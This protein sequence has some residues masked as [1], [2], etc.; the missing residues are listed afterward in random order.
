MIYP[1]Y[2][3]RG[4]HEENRLKIC[5]ICLKKSKKMCLINEKIISFI[6]KIENYNLDDIKYPKVVCNVCKVKVYKC[7]KENDFSLNLT[8]L[9][10]FSL[11]KQSTRNSDSIIC[12]CFLCKLISE[13]SKYNFFKKTM[14]VVKKNSNIKVKKEKFEKRCPDCFNIIGCGIKHK[15]NF[16][17]LITNVINKASE[18]D[19]KKKVQLA[20]TL[21]K[22]AIQKSSENNKVQ[23]ETDLNLSQL[24]GKPVK[25]SV[26]PSEPKKTLIRVDDLCKLKTNLNLSDR[27]V[28]GVSQ[29]I[30]EST[31]NRKIIE[32]HAREKI[33]ELSHSFDEFFKCEELNFVSVKKNKATLCKSQFVMCSDLEGLITHIAKKRDLPNMTFHI[34]FGLD[35]GGGFLKI[36]MILQESYEEMVENTTGIKKRKPNYN[37]DF[38]FS[39]VKKIFLLG[40]APFVQENY[41]NLSMIWSRLKINVLDMYDTAITADLKLAN[42]ICGLMAH[43]SQHPCTWCDA[44]KTK[45]HCSGNYR[46]LGDIKTNY[47]EWVSSGLAKNE[48]KLFKNCIGE[49]IFTCH[50]NNARILDLIPPPQLHLFLGGVN[51]LFK[52][53]EKEF[54]QIS[55]IWAKNCKVEKKIVN[56]APSFEGNSC[57]KLLNKVDVLRSLANQYCINCLK[58]VKA[59]EKLKMVVDACFSIDLDPNFDVYIDEFKQSYMD[60]KI[61]VTPKI[62]SIFFHVR[63][64]CKEKEK[65]LGFF[66]E[67]AVESIH[68]DFK[69][70][71]KN[72]KVPITHPEYSERLLRT[73]CVYNSLH[74]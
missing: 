54:S 49:P 53:M 11:L 10:K 4:N 9:N 69:E 2:K 43:A 39:G 5:L 52:N 42:I 14:K 70:N 51:T 59:F 7:A 32:P 41:E 34:K 23:Q 21:L 25:I 67:Q 68:H 71:W 20:S 38:K 63:D 17:N 19:E 26:N 65:G 47:S 40:V 74:L 28:N 30:R 58:Y 24:H 64:F 13:K 12:K 31:N 44:L 1:N 56:G 8:N 50:D 48:A 16:T 36:C 6:I 22:T 66:T 35:G 3:K 62:H 33:L 73:V 57:N 72:F 27:Q 61:P 55:L 45:L 60:L 29:F 15:C 46:T 37:K 18:L